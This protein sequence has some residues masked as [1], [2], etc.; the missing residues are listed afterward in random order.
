MIES[1]EIKNFGPIT[2]LAWQDLAPVN[3]VIGRNGSGKT[4]LLKALYCAVRTLEEKCGK[5]PRSDAEILADKLHWTFQPD[6][7]GDLVQ[8]RCDGSLSVKLMLKNLLLS[9]DLAEELVFSFDSG[10]T[11]D[12]VQFSSQAWRPNSNSVFLPAKEV[13]SLHE[14]ILR[15]REDF[16]LF[17]FDDTYVDLAKALQWQP[18][19]VGFPKPLEKPM[20]EL[21]DMLGGKVELQYVSK[22]NEIPTQ[23]WRFKRGGNDFSI[24]MTAEG[25][26]KIAILDTLFRNEHLSKGSII[27]IDEPEAALHPNAAVRFLVVLHHRHQDIPAI[28]AQIGSAFLINIRMRPH[29]LPSSAPA[30]CAHRSLC[31]RWDTTRASGIPVG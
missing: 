11:R 14:I 30:A 9:N 1:I 25:A 22:P 16:R 21:E 23:L 31:V 10:A 4:F 28:E 20:A 29:P 24:G 7:I 15:S 18:Q 27:F 12:D 2:A 26:K 5:E 17:G 8:K 6:K 3:L 19:I 13:L